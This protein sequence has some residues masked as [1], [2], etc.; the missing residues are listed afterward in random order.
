M[1]SSMTGYGR[2]AVEHDGRR[3]EIELKSVNHRYL[4]LSY[5]MSKSIS[6]CEDTLR[7]RIGLKLSRGHVDV[8]VSYVNNREDARRLAVDELV[9][10][11]YI[12]AARAIAD[13][14]GVACD[15]DALSLLRLPNATALEEAEDDREA[16]LALM[17]EAVD[18]ALEQLVAS[19]RNEGERLRKSFC[20]CLDAIEDLAKRIE[21]R[22]PV[23]V[24]EYARKL[25]ERIAAHLDGSAIIDE[26]R[27]AMEVALFADR[28]SI[29]E[30]LVRIASHIEKLRS[31]LC[32]DGAVGRTFE[33]Y[34]QE[35]N[36]EFNTIGS[37]ANDALVT[38]C[39]VSGKAVLE[40]I[41]E[42]IQNIE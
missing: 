29:N 36:R 19:R 28:A 9:V 35:L 2:A 16:I 22:E 14:Y 41:R 11:A 37:K 21:D 25:H 6:F 3:V 34:T 1:I 42:Q 15:L 38:D 39:V 40:K 23:V 13:K 8:Y 26:G 32:T 10:A 20:D 33:F 7:K 18:A 4:D 5:R 30:E 31:L 17:S 27:L 24:E 12:G